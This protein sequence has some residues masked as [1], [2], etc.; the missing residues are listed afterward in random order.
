[1]ADTPEDADMA[2]LM[3][4]RPMG[5]PPLSPKEVLDQPVQAWLNKAQ[6]AALNRYMQRHSIS[7][8]GK[9]ARELILAGLR[10]EGLLP[11]E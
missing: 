10:A 9:A 4:K 3:A 8:E 11:N 6:R 2:L 1:M 5:R 7:R